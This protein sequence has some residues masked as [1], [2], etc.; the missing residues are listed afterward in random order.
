MAEFE[1]VVPNS[2]DRYDEFLEFFERQI[3][4]SSLKRVARLG[5]ASWDFSG[6]F[7]SKGSLQVYLRGNN[8]CCRVSTEIEAFPIVIVIILNLLIGLIFLVIALSNQKKMEREIRTAVES[9]RTQILISAPKK[10]VK[11]PVVEEEKTMDCPGCGE[12]LP[13][14]ANFCPHCGFQLE[15]CMVC[16]LPLGG[17]K[18]IRCPYCSGL[19]HRDHLLEYIKVKGKCPICG[20]KLKK[21]ELV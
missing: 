2:A 11:I 17:D 16:N 4:I 14:D 13:K 10:P 7:L 18:I 21:D 12:T 6:G 20:K 1:I 9:A 19:A 8:I 15:K 3:K 5:R